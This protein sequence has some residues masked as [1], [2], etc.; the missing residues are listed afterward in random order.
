MH[1]HYAHIDPP[2]TPLQMLEFASRAHARPSNKFDG[3]YYGRRRNSYAD[4]GRRF[5]PKALIKL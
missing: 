5:N 3:G 1:A 4:L 2:L